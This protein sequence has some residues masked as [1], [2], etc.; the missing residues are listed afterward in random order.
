MVDYGY[1]VM[2]IVD[3]YGRPGTG[4]S[5]GSI[6]NCV[7]VSAGT[8]NMF[9]PAKLGYRGRVR[10]GRWRVLI[11]ASMRG[12]AD[13]FNSSMGAARIAEFRSGQAGDVR[14]RSDM[15][16]RLLGGRG[17]G[18]WAIH[19]AGCARCGAWWRCICVDS[20]RALAFG[21]SIYFTE[22][23]GSEGWEVRVSES[24]RG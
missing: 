7:G 4:P 12:L 14:R 2:V 23:P 22:K 13:R 18:N 8:G 6:R 20:V 5:A 21:V 3:W 16:W 10:P 11:S 9:G 24:D 15:D 17:G 1:H 19:P